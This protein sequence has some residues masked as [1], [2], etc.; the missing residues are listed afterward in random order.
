MGTRRRGTS[1]PPR[2]Q[3]AILRVGRTDAHRSGHALG[4]SYERNDAGTRSPSLAAAMLRVV[5]APDE[6]DDFRHHGA[7]RRTRLPGRPMASWRRRSRSRTPGRASCRGRGYPP[8]APSLARPALR[9]DR[10]PCRLRQDERHWSSG[11][12]GSATHRLADR[13]RDRQ[14]PRDLPPPTCDKPQP[15]GVRRPSHRHRHRVGRGPTPRHRGPP[16]VVPGGSAERPLLVAIDDA[17]RLSDRATLDALAEFI[18]YLPAGAQL[19]AAGREPMDM[20]LE[21]WRLDGT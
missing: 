6:R 13:R 11:P 9:L 21:R 7:E 14:R 2:R 1:G 4:Y 19:A 20:P 18:T 10:R 8:S 17:H 3:A 12:S 5:A 16:A 15:R